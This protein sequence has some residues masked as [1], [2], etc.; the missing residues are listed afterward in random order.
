[1]TKSCVWL[2]RSKSKAKFPSESTNQSRLCRIDPTCLWV[3]QHPRE[4]GFVNVHSAEQRSLRPAYAEQTFPG[5][6]GHIL[7]NIITSEDSF[8]FA[9]SPHSALEEKK[10][11]NQH[12]C[13]FLS[14]LSQPECKKG[15]SVLSRI[16]WL[17]KTTY[18]P[19]PDYPAKTHNLTKHFLVV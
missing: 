1:M 17:N 7:I 19:I 12:F 6:N 8:F 5:N 9:V 15:E 10:Q 16:L 18:W 11:T 13:F 14:V 4:Y 2:N 3:L